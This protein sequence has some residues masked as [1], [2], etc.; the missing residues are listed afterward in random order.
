MYLGIYSSLWITI[1]YSRLSP[2]QQIYNMRFIFG[3]QQRWKRICLDLLSVAVGGCA[4][5]SF[6]ISG[7]KIQDN[8]SAG[9]VG[10]C[11]KNGLNGV[12]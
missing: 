6:K 11:L 10:K 9:A 2:N 12:A 3:N 5:W 1:R 7:E 8:F 4:K